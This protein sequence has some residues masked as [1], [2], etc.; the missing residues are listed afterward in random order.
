[1]W[2]GFTL[3]IIGVAGIAL[4]AISKVPLLLELSEKT[5]IID[6]EQKVKEG[7]EEKVKKEVKGILE[8]FLQAFLRS[9]RKIIVKTEQV[10]TK[11]L[12]NLKRKKREEKRK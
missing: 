1:M 3:T 8:D 6:D 7:I 12:Y 4:F 2:I 10:T 11:W 9:V 5:S